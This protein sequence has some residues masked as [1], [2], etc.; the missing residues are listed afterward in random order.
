M[1]RASSI[2]WVIFLAL[3]GLFTLALFGLGLASRLDPDF[4]LPEY[5]SDDW[6]DG[7]HSDKDSWRSGEIYGFK[8][9]RIRRVARPKAS[10]VDA[11]S[12]TFYMSVRMSKE[13]FSSFLNRLEQDKKYEFR[14]G[15]GFPYND[16]LLPPDWFP[17]I[18]QENFIGFAK[19]DSSWSVYIFRPTDSDHT[20]FVLK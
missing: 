9:D 11:K 7:D 3:C 1:P 18:S 6:P 19:D 12:I 5:V 13:D 2:L 4:G 20:F 8:A 10:G 17:A 15:G 14:F 16:I